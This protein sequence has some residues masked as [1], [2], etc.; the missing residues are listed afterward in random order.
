MSLLVLRLAALLALS[1]PF[2][3]CAA[4]AESEDVGAEAG[5]IIGGKKATAYP[6]A[7]LLDLYV[8][9]S[10]QGYCSGSVIAPKVVLTA[11]HCVHQITSWRIAVPYAAGQTAAGTS[12]ATYDWTS[13]AETV[14]P[15]M[16][17]IGLVF[18]STPITLSSYPT[19]A[20]SPVASG[21]KVVNIGR[22]D[23]GAFSTTNLYVSQPSTVTKGAASGFPYDYA[24]RE[25][26]QS[27]DSGGPDM[28]SGTHTIVAV[29]SGAG[30][31]TEVLARVDL[32]Y[33]WLQQQI[34][35]H[36]G[37]DAS[38]VIAVVPGDP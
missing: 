19:L 17:D 29:N 22:I 13:S 6:E 34:A 20:S 3:A 9:G 24:A 28:A 21:A 10:L 38:D 14:D 1:A 7:A 18:L 31:G 32:L 8:D 16:H 35:A 37:A 23:N 33:S 5:A 12:G 2:V 25:Q 27:G 15:T 30:S 4:P 26:I 36:G 11:G